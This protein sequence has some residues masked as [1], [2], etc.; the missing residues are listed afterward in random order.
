MEIRWK[1]SDI[2]KYRIGVNANI[3]HA[4]NNNLVLFAMSPI[5]PI[6]RFKIIMLCLEEKLYDIAKKNFIRLM[7]MPVNIDLILYKMAE[8]FWNHKCVT[9]HV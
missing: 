6:I 5:T 1:G 4:N 8:N 9:L 2:N 3:M 7:D